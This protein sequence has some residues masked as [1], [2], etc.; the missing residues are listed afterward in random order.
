MSWRLL[1]CEPA[2]AGWLLAVQ[3]WLALL[4][5]YYQGFGVAR[6]VILCGLLAG[7]FLLRLLPVPTLARGT[8]GAGYLPPV[9]RAL[10]AAALLL[11]LGM[12]I[13]SGTTSVQS[14]KIPMDEGQTSWR[15]ARLLRQGENPY[16]AGV[17]VDFGAYRSRAPQR[18]AAGIDTPLAGAALTAAL[19][20]YDRSLDPV[21]PGTLLPASADAKGAAARE[22]R[23]YGYKYGPV[24]LLATVLV[25]PFGIPA[26]VLLL[27]GLVCFALYAVNWRILRRL[28][29]P[30]FALAGVAMLALLLD[31][32]I[33]RN[34]ID[35]SATDVWALLFGSLAVLAT[36]SRRPL[37]AATAIA[38]AI[39]CKSMP[40][41]LFAP[42]LLRFRSPVPLL[43]CAAL[44]GALYL[45]WLIWDSAGVLY[46]VF[47]WPFYMACDFTSWQ[48]FAPWWC[49]PAARIAIV[50]S[51]AVLWFRY[52]FGHKPRLFWT[53]AVSSTFVLLASGFLR[54]GYVPWASLWAVAAIVEAFAIRETQSKQGEISAAPPHAAPAIESAKSLA[55]ART[56]L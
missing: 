1:G 36:M 40:G 20:R 15:A 6:G 31:R 13:V 49:A 17:L 32:H 16:G 43:L 24:I 26:A 11:D 56:A 3:L 18:R 12:M 51:L 41:L 38:L 35:R 50:C 4:W 7:L 45:P 14:S 21:I 8:A 52:V 19:A 25:T 30:Q 10:L 27:N 54:N 28:A 37:A 5:F 22:T 42:L 23:M 48:F 34:Y 2:F 47:L 53:L 33:T 55:L 46:N 9:L 29:S 44:T 39:G